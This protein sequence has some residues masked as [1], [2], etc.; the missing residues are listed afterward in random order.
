MD[1]GWNEI[2]T[3]ADIKVPTLFKYVIKYIT[4]I[5]LGFVFFASIPEIWDKIT[6]KEIY[7]AIAAATSQGEIDALETKML[8]VNIS[9]AGL[10][11]V[12]LGIAYFV[13]VAYRKR[14]REG[15]FTS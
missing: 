10:L 3:G 12:W 1:K 8:F 9:R 4:P 13:H 6:N 11:L 15:R 14:I 2:N 5:I 7:A